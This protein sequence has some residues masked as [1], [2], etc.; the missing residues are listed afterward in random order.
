MNACACVR[1]A[2]APLRACANGFE[3]FEMMA[4]VDHELIGEHE[5]LEYQY[6]VSRY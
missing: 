6:L 3:M 5:M 4:N 2:L 1:G